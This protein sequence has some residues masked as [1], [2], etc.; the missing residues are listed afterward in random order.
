MADTSSQLSSGAMKRP[1]PVISCLE[2]RR[3]KLKCDRTQPCQQCIKIGRPGQCEY[4]SGQE[5]LPNIAY[6]LMSP[7]K[8]QRIYSPTDDPLDNDTVAL[9]GSHGPQVTSAGR[10]VIEDLQ[11]RVARL[12]NAVLAGNARREGVQDPA[13]A[14]PT[15]PEAS[16][17]HVDEDDSTSASHPLKSLVSSVHY[18]RMCSD[19]TDS[20]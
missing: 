18:A 7:A 20:P 11:E 9:N 3:K 4:Q 8:R 19:S 2:C 15:Y 6:S 5:P 1:R 14:T 16:D 13:P 12:E 17:N 10:G